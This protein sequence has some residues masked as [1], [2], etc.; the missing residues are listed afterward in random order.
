M[1][2]ADTPD[3]TRHLFQILK[4]RARFNLALKRSSVVD[5]EVIAPSGPKGA[6]SELLHQAWTE[7]QAAVEIMEEAHWTSNADFVVD[8]W[9]ATAAMLGK[10][11]EF[12]P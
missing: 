11:R 1:A 12:P 2:R 4:A 3:S 5:G 7:I 9:V 10:Q 6:D 8:I